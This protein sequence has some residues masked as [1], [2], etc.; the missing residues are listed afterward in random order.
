VKAFTTKANI[1][2][3]SGKVGSRGFMSVTIAALLRLAC[4]SEADVV[5]ENQ[6]VSG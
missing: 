2:F 6:G 3:T 4:L 5:A 1:I